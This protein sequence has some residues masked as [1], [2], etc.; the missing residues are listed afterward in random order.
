MY[1]YICMCACVCVCMHTKSPQLCPTF[2]DPMDCSLPGSSVHG[3]LQTRI[4]EWVANSLLQGIFLTQGSNPCLLCLLY[5]QVSSLLLV[6]PGKPLQDDT[7]SNYINLIFKI[8]KFSS[9]QLLSHIQL[10]DPMDCSTPGFP[11]HHQ[12]LE[13]T[14]T[15]VH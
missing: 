9:V 14:Q 11:V 4:L 12:L 8:F 10:C 6:P 2:G 3:L 1:I 15:H 5:W 7:R 13:F